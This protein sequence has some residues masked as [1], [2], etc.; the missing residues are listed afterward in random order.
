MQEENQRRLTGIW[1]EI[2]KIAQ[3][4]QKAM[5]EAGDD[6]EKQA[7]AKQAALKSINILCD[8]LNSM[9]RMLDETGRNAVNAIIKTLRENMIKGI[10][11]GAAAV[12]KEVAVATA[13]GTEAGQIIEKE[14]RRAAN[15][16]K[17]ANRGNQ[18]Y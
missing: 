12:A 1:D 3:E 7:R 6:A 8:V 15:A 13:A 5:T 18:D 17:N 16:L 9:I 4:Y 11:S 2:D 10:E 14:S